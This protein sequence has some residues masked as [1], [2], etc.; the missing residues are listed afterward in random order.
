MFR[1]IPAAGL[2]GIWLIFMLPGVSGQP[3]PPVS[4]DAKTRLNKPET[5]DWMRT[6]GRMARAQQDSRMETLANGR[7]DSKT[8]RS[9][10]M[11]CSGL[12]YLGNPKAQACVARAYEHGIGIIEDLTEAHVWYTV[13][14]ENSAG[15]A[16]ARE[17]L[18]S[19]LDRIS[20]RLHSTY[21]SPSEEELEDL[22]KAEKDRITQ[23]RDELKKTKK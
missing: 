17:R 19:D 23:Y 12:A 4:E 9:D 1:K 2:I 11:F 10:F 14:L 5:L 16:A 7:P 21:P 20:L 8:P 18:Q 3:S 22:V 15:D 6:I 13:A